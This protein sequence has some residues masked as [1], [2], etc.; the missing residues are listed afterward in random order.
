M[1]QN[2]YYRYLEVNLGDLLQCYC[3]ATNTNSGTIRSQASQPASASKGAGTSDLQDHLS[4]HDT[5]KANLV[6]VQCECH[7]DKQTV[8]ARIKPINRN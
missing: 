1:W 8:I 5:R 6:L 7:T 4:L 3:Y 2:A